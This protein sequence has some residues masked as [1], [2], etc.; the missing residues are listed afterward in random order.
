MSTRI[1]FLVYNHFAVPTLKKWV[2]ISNQLILGDT[3]PI[4]KTLVLIKPD[5]VKRHL[6]GEVIKTYEA[7]GLVIRQMKMYDSPERQLKAHY[8]CHEGKSFY[9]KLMTFMMSGPIIAMVIEGQDAVEIVRRINGATDPCSAEAGSIRGR[10][11]T[12]V[13]ENC[14]HGSDSVLTAE[15]EISIWFEA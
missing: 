12:D 6:V 10:F 13:T 4:E 11:A 14:V 7:K 3:M 1:K 9:Q 5:I 2:Y 15:K 8:F